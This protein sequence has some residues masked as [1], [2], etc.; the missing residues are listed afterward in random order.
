MRCRIGDLAFIVRPTVPSNL[1]ALVEVV[2]VWSDHPGCWWV[3]S[4]SGPRMRKNGE[5]AEDGMVPDE[6]LRP[7]RGDLDVDAETIEHILSEAFHG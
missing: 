1:G 6:G 4:L 5:V 2:A 3:R 7:L